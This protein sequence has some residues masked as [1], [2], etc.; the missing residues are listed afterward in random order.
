MNLKEEEEEKE[1]GGEGGGGGGLSFAPRAPAVWRVNRHSIGEG[2]GGAGV[3]APRLLRDSG[4]EF[5]IP[6]AR[7]ASERAAAFR[8]RRVRGS[9]SS[10]YPAI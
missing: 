7:G 1:G 6:T 8:S 5:E 4:N 3:P 2:G 10:A 9:L